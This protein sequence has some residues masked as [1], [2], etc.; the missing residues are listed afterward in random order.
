MKYAINVGKSIRVGASLTILHVLAILHLSL[1][2]IVTFRW[3]SFTFINDS[4]DTFYCINKSLRTQH[5]LKYAINVG[6]SIRVGA[7][8]TILHV[9]AILHLSLLVI[10]TFRWISF[11]FINDS[12]DTFYCINKSL[13]TQHSLKYAINVVKSISVG[14]SLTILPS[15]YSSF[16]RDTIN[17]VVLN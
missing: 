8:L 9:L 16:L 14:A 1:L 5:S 10:V 4:G 12:G 3:I 13:K 6:K 17:S 11:T 2:V 7:S 15:G